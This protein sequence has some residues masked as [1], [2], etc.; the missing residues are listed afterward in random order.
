MVS[1][2][3]LRAFLFGHYFEKCKTIKSLFV[4]FSNGCVLWKLKD[5]IS[6]SYHVAY[7]FITRIT[8]IAVFLRL[9]YY[10]LLT[11]ITFKIK[12]LAIFLKS[13]ALTDVCIREDGRSE[14]REIKLQ[15]LGRLDSDLEVIINI[16]LLVQKLVV[17]NYRYKN[18]LQK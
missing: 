10:R 17:E 9:H 16:A 5:K 18:E 12:R 7:K 15:F 2:V 6:R 4:T 8:R 14:N 11:F 13:L 1:Y 3:F